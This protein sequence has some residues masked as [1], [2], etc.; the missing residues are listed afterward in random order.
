VYLYAMMAKQEG[1][2]LGNASLAARTPGSKEPVYVYLPKD[3]AAANAVTEIMCD[4]MK[5]QMRWER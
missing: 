4:I 1:A 2:F 5:Q 3:P